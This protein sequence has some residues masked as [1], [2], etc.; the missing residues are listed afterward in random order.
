MTDRA[1]Y[2]D[3]RAIDQVAS[4]G[5]GRLSAVTWRLMGSYKWGYK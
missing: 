3:G 5:D 1:V 4:G 2:T